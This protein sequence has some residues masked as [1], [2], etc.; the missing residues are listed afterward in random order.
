[1]NSMCRKRVTVLSESAAAGRLARDGEAT[2]LLQ[3]Q[4]VAEMVAALPPPPTSVP[5]AAP[6]LS[7]AVINAAVYGDPQPAAGTKALAP[8]ESAEMSA[9]PQP[10]QEMKSSGTRKVH[11]TKLPTAIPPFA[12]GYE[13]PELPAEYIPPRGNGRCEAVAA[14]TAATPLPGAATSTL[15]APANGAPVS[16]PPASLEAL[17]ASIAE[18]VSGSSA[19]VQAA[20]AKRDGMR[21]GKLAPSDFAASVRDLGVQMYVGDLRNLSTASHHL[22]SD[23]IDY[24]AFIQS[25]EPQLNSTA[26][27]IATRPPPQ[28]DAPRSKLDH[29][30]LFGA[31]AQ[32]PRSQIALVA[33]VAPGPALAAAPP[34]LRE[35]SA[36]AHSAG[37]GAEPTP[38]KDTTL[39]ARGPAYTVASTRRHYANSDFPSDTDHIIFGSDGDPAADNARRQRQVAPEGVVQQAIRTNADRVI[40]GH[41]M[42]QSAKRAAA[43]ELV[44]SLLALE[45]VPQTPR[46]SRKEKHAP[47]NRAQADEVIFGHDI[48][49]SKTAPPLTASLSSAF[50]GAA[51]LDSLGVARVTRT[52]A[53]AINA[54]DDTLIQPEPS[55]ALGATIRPHHQATADGVIF[56]RDLDA[57]DVNPDTHPEADAARAAGAAG[58]F[59]PREVYDNG[60][61]NAPHGVAHLLSRSVAS[62]TGAWAAPPTLGNLDAGRASRRR[63]IVQMSSVPSGAPPFG[64]SE[65]P[66]QPPS[67]SVPRAA[68]NSLEPADVQYKIL[69][70]S[71]SPPK[72]S[73][74]VTAA[75][76]GACGPSSISRKTPSATASAG[77]GSFAR[78][79]SQLN[80]LSGLLSSTVRPSS[81]TQG[82]A[83]R[84]SVERNATLTPGYLPS[85]AGSKRPETSGSYIGAAG[86]RSAR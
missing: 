71:R 79:P 65:P 73:P 24:L 61:R 83:G 37:L 55:R 41:A 33:E 27:A 31:H 43:S 59:T 30:R 4:R 67:P 69:R 12:L 39:C 6:P 14:A 10:Y 32:V 46:S 34:T 40:F 80:M 28:S 56:G 84:A 2:L 75:Y 86:R 78:T 18:Q 42:G 81:S 58:Q 74:R 57:S 7:P 22:T 53:C 85:Y 77:Q 68:T 76:Q 47:H 66:P 23:T 52:N 3:Q 5:S 60:K 11:T 13:N 35:H 49:G 38:G 8:K 17:R 21:Q 70:I 48:D 1:L 63:P 19:R 50:E 29:R 44:P 45:P 51:G 82:A 36:F 26:A 72:P 20:F 25:L 62:S 54:F 64:L 16:M 9:L 15:G